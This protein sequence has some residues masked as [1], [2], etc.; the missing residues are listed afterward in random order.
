MGA[1]PARTSTAVAQSLSPGA[2]PTKESSPQ[3]S[4][5][6]QI[7]WQRPRRNRSYGQE[8]NARLQTPLQQSQRVLDR[9]RQITA[10]VSSLAATRLWSE[11]PPG[12]AVHKRRSWS[13]ESSE[14]RQT[15]SLGSAGQDQATSQV[16]AGLTLQELLGLG[17]TE[18]SKG[19]VKPVI[20]QVW[21]NG[22]RG[23]DP[24][25]YSDSDGPN[26]ALE[27]SDSNSSDAVAELL[28]QI[29]QLRAQASL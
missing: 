13:T 9:K 28:S 1:R 22:R 19:A 8:R 5:E 25:V 18:G 7:G 27:T 17:P 26:S 14:M 11:C 4:T 16:P 29:S 3:A 2:V 6:Q 15:L 24:A 21:V 20:Q 10:Q 23:F 12:Q